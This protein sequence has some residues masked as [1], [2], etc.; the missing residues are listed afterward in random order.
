MAAPTAIAPQTGASVLQAPLPELVV[1]TAPALVAEPTSLL[2]LLAKL[3]ASLFTLLAK[4]VPSLFQLLATLSALLI[5]A[6]A[7][8]FHA[9][10]AV[11]ATELKL[12][13]ALEASAKPVD[14]AD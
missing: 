8:L 13:S 11:A 2:T 9:P 5:A 3:V 4:L 7:L 14:S 1:L 6:S 12:A 10:V